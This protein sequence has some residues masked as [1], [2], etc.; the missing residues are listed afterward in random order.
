MAMQKTRFLRNYQYFDSENP[1]DF[2]WKPIKNH[3]FREHVFEHFHR[4]TDRNPHMPQTVIIV[5]YIDAY[6]IRYMK[7]DLSG[8]VVLSD[9]EGFGS[10][11]ELLCNTEGSRHTGGKNGRISVKLKK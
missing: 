7:M 6:N 11:V 2:A 4:K 5:G 3:R 8:C 1:L 9:F 10:S